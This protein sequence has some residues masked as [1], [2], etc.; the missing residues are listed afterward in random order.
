MHAALAELGVLAAAAA[1]FVAIA[2]TV[3]G[4]QATG[5]RAGATA[6]RQPPS[7]TREPTHAPAASDA[8][9]QRR[10]AWRQAIDGRGVPG[11]PSPQ[12]RGQ[13]QRRHRRLP[14]GA[15]QRADG[16]E[17]GRS[18]PT[19]KLALFHGTRGST[20][21]TPAKSTRT[22]PRSHPTGAISADWVT[23]A[24]AYPHGS[25]YTYKVMLYDRNSRQPAH[26]GRGA[27]AS[28]ARSSK[29]VLGHR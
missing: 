15:G 13:R 17:L 12:R 28:R 16:P 18:T 29:L 3:L 25:D 2:G 24:V 19:S 27:G 7:A 8:C 11:G 22:F 6:L 4:I 10:P 5:T 26:A 9:A 23:F 1:V 20:I 21:Y 14:C